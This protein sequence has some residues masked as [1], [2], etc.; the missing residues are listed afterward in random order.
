MVLISEMAITICQEHWALSFLL[1]NSV[2]SGDQPTQQETPNNTTGDKA[3]LQPKEI[4]SA[5]RKNPD[6]PQILTFKNSIA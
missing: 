2:T 1:N 3:T 6:K 5:L 4:E